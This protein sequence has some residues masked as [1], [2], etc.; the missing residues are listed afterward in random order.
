MCI[1]LQQTMKQ[2]IKQILSYKKKYNLKKQEKTKKTK[3]K[4]KQNQKEGK[5]YLIIGIY[6]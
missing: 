3:A 5:L 1:E 2:E 4:K 6:W